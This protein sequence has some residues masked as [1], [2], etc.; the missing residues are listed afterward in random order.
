MIILFRA[1]LERYVDGRKFFLCFV[2]NPQVHGVLGQLGASGS[3]RWCLAPSLRPDDT[4]EDYSTDRCLTLVR[5]AVG[6]AELPAVIEDASSWEIAARLAD[7]FRAGRVLLVGDAAHVM[8]P[9]GGFGGNMG[10]QDAHNL[11]WKL[12]LVLRGTADARLLDSYE[13]ERIPVA[14]FTTEQG[15]IRYLQRS[16][17]DPETA[18]RHQPEVTVL[19][20]HGYRSDA[21]VSADDDP[22][23][24]E[25]PGH[26][27]GRPGTRAT[28]LPLRHQGRETTVAELVHRDFALLA[29][30]GGR[31]WV[32]A[33]AEVAT[34]IGLPLDRYL[35]GA[36]PDATLVDPTGEFPDRYGV[37][38]T[39]AVLVRPDGF[40]AW[41]A[42][43]LTGDPVRTLA[44]VFGQL[45]GTDAP[46]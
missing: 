26:A 27:S 35:V 21:V 10:V 11:A 8:P 7:R 16:G 23:L 19:F 46:R 36:E 38:R 39:G 44:D 9:T 34:R 3:D 4:H 41:R 14:E 32:D 12:A 22:A 17:L 6:V 25:H 13:T 5:A 45:L 29:A 43:E 2:S 24:V 31:E 1:D 40:V 28:H 15:V 20:G 33:G 30:P 42:P 37:S 18:A